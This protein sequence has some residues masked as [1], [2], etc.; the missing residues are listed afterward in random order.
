MQLLAGDDIARFVISLHSVP[1]WDA[2]KNAKT[3]AELRVLGVK[4]KKMGAELRVLGVKMK[5]WAQNS[6]FLV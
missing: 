5:K 2:C 1:S 3:G 6:E 4:M